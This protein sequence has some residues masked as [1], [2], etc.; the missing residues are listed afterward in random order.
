MGD[1]D[2]SVLGELPHHVQVRPHV[3]LAADQHHFGTGTELLRLTLPLWITRMRTDERNARLSAASL[4]SAPVGRGFGPEFGHLTFGEISEVH[5]QNRGLELEMLILS[6]IL[7]GL[8]F[9]GLVLD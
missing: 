5:V 4:A 3:Q 7:V 8:K 1:G 2:E 9:R 6:K